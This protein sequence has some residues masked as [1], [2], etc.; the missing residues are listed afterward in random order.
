MIE[1]IVLCIFLDDPHLITDLLSV[2]QHFPTSIIFYLTNE[3]VQYTFLLYW[4]Q[5]P[6]KIMLKNFAIANICI[7]LII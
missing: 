7:H 2:S 4:V 5:N 6:I 1:Y 3:Y